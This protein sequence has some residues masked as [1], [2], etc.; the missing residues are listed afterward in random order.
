[1][2]PA[3]TPSPFAFLP[4]TVLLLAVGLG[5][6]LVLFNFTVPNL[7]PRWLFF[8]LVTVAF[9]GLALPAVSFLNFRFP[10][11][12]PAPVRVIVRQALWVGV[13]AATVA[14]LQFGRVFNT[15]LAVLTAFAF[16]F[17]EWVLRLRERSRWESPE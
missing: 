4:T 10:S 2:I 11:D 5:G 15:A 1:M 14:W 6:L 3:R 9:T 13:Y 16:I 17:I 8:F 12:P 7:F